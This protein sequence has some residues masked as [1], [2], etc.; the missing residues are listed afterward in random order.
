MVAEQEVNIPSNTSSSFEEN[1]V[2]QDSEKDFLT[3]SNDVPCEMPRKEA[4]AYIAISIVC[5]M[6]AFGGFVFGW[7]TGTISGFVKQTDFINRFGNTR[8]DGTKY[9]SKIRT[10]LIVSLFNL[11]SLTGSLLLSR[12]GDM[13]G[14]RK[15]LSISCVIYIIGIIVEIA[16]IRAWYQYMIG[17]YFAGIGVGGLTVYSPML[18]SEVAPKHLRG[19][20][21]AVYQCMNAFAVFL[22]GCANF[23]TA[24]YYNDSRQWRIPLGLCFAWA[25]IMIVAVSIIT[26][27]PRYL[28]E[29]GKIEEAKMSIAKSNR[30]DE[31]D[32]SIDAELSVIEA[33]VALENEG[34]KARWA[35][36]FTVKTKHLHRS[37]MGFGVQCLNQLSGINFFL[38]YGNQLFVGVGI[39]NPYE[40]SIVL[41]L[42]DFVASTFTLYIIEH[43]GRRNCLLYGSAIQS[44]SLII[45]SSLGVTRLYPHGLNN[46]ASRGA[47]QCMIVFTCL[48]LASFSSTW[49]PIS[50][51]V[52]AE[53]FPL[54]IRAKGIGFC[55]AGNWLFNFLISLF[56]PLITGAIHYNYGFVFMS[57][58]I[59]SYFFVYLFVPE[60]KGLSLEDINTM[61]LEGVLPWK[62]TEWVPPSKRDAEYDAAAMAKDDQ[63]FYQKV[64][65]S[66]G[67]P[68]IR[69]NSSAA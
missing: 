50:H 57:C 41:G 16:S 7:D 44:I 29:I 15:A 13:Y 58:M 19:T 34:G 30:L 35:D 59:T 11:G 69:K 23:G 40:T 43:F 42:V 48:F 67:L 47:D 39:D 64:L 12:L 52:V 14:R 53:S 65:P 51:V 24:I 54:K 66:F 37:F 33:G 21:I 55:N 49:A 27:S 3:Q 25:L 56:S 28:V 36:L 20:L 9:F 5:S 18:I 46:K 26:E 45:Y 63:K 31:G 8:A 32:P 38:Y 10:G 60:T 62:S 68:H 1:Q 6:I 17:R 4:S 22:G 2:K 61:W